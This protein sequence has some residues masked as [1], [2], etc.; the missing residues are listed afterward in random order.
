MPG[1][2]FSA[3]RI[4]LSPFRT[5]IEAAWKSV[6]PIE[7]EQWMKAEL[8][9]KYHSFIQIVG[10]KAFNKILRIHFSP[11]HMR[12]A[13]LLVNLQMPPTSPQAKEAVKKANDLAESAI[14]L[15]T[16]SQ[17]LLNIGQKMADYYAEHPLDAVANLNFRDI[18]AAQDSITKRMAV[19]TQKDM[20]KIQMARLFS[21][22]LPKEFKFEEGKLVDENG[23]ESLIRLLAGNQK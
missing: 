18:M 12:K 16:L 5:Q 23:A 6:T 17:S 11:N 8:F 15:N 1:E 9:R 3:C 4:C 13:K 14:T 19:E 10:K 20:V 21:G 7:R 22:Q 2:P